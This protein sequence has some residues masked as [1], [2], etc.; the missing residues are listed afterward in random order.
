MLAGLQGSG[1]TT[2]AGKL[3]KQLKKK[4]RNPML[5]A[6][7]L[8]RPAAVQQL[9]VNAEKVGVHVYAPSN[10]ATRCRWLATA[11]TRPCRPAATS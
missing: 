2:A 6:C 7:D 9:R 8:Q 4:G 11:S 5:V 3:A 1:K 10:P